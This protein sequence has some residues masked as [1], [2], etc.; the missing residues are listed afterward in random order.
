MSVGDLNCDQTAI[1]ATAELRPR[2]SSVI[3]L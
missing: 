3:A 2:M 1:G